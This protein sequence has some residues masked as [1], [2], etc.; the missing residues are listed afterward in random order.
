MPRRVMLHRA[1]FY[2]KVMGLLAPLHAIERARLRTERREQKRLARLERERLE[3]ERRQQEREERYVTPIA[4]VL[5]NVCPPWLDGNGAG[6]ACAG[7]LLT[8]TAV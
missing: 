5:P 7:F 8:R 1:L 6:A 2:G 4:S 3:A